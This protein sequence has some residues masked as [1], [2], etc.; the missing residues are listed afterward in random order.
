MNMNSRNVTYSTIGDYQLPNLTLPR[1]EKTLGKYGR[2]RRTY[3]MKH[4]PV[5]YNSIATAFGEYRQHGERVYTDAL[6]VLAEAWEGDI[7]SLRSEVLQ[8]VTRFVALYDHEYD[9]I[10]LIRQLQRTSPIAIYRSGQAMSGPNHQKYMLQVLKAYNGSSR[11][12]SLP[13]KQ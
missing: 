3:L 8:G 1:Q 2:L 9:P 7:D 5:L 11:T 4:R 10:R 12:K 13:I 6:R